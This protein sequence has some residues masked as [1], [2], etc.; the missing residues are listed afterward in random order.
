MLKYKY[1]NFKGKI[2]NMKILFT[3]FIIVSLF[4]FAEYAFP[5]NLT[6]YE[7]LKPENNSRLTNI[8]KNNLLLNMVT[9]YQR[10]ISINNG[11]KCMFYPT[12]SEFFKEAVVK[13]GPIWAILMTVDRMFYRENNKSMKLYPYLESYER[14]YDPIK[15]HFIFKVKSK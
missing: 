8:E 10:K 11:P 12:C 4:M 6:T 14:Y 3:S 1:L 2:L 9:W 15:N 13:Y 7:I 5:D